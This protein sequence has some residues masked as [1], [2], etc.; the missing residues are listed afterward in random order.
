LITDPVSVC[1]DADGGLYV[2]ETL[3]VIVEPLG[4]SVLAVGLSSTSATAVLV[5]GQAGLQ[6]LRFEGSSETISNDPAA[7]AL[8]GR[9]YRRPF[10]LPEKA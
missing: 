5:P 9:E 3:S 2:V 10:V 4:W 8:L 1:F 6:T 7:A